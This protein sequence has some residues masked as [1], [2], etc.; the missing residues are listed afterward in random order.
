M[1]TL[2]QKLWL[3]CPERPLLL[4][5]SRFSHVRLCAAPQRAAHQ[6]PLSLGFS[7]QERP[8]LLVI[9]FLSK[10]LNLPK[11]VSKSD[12]FQLQDP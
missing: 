5:L 1:W 10:L 2:Q 4:L 9:F 7:R 8:Q 11:S 3:L 6:A 12:I